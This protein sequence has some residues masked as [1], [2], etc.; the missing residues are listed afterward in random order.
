MRADRLARAQVIAVP[1]TAVCR[2]Y[3]QNIQH[4]LT[5]Y[6]ASKLSGDDAHSLGVR[7]RVPSSPAHRHSSPM[8]RHSHAFSNE[9]L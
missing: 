7:L 4:P 1:V 5:R 2:V 8:H 9:L 6:V 3:L